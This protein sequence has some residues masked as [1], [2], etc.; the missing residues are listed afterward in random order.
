[1]KR[2]LASK[3]LDLSCLLLLAPGTGCK[4]LVDAPTEL[5]ELSAY[6]FRNFENTDV[7]VLS[8]GLCNLD[9]F[10]S[11]VDLDQN[12]SDLAYSLDP[13]TMDDL[14][15]IVHPD[16]DPATTL[17]V[18]LV[19]ASAFGPRE[20][21]DVILLEDQTPVEPNSPNQYD[22]EFT[23]PG[24]PECF[25]DQDCVL[26]RSMNDI[27]KE[28]F[29]M[30]I[31]YQMHKDF[32]WIEMCEEG[33]TNWAVL[34][35]SWC[36]DEAWG[37]GGDNVILQSYSIDVFMPSNDGGVRY[38]ALWSESDIAGFGD[39][40]VEYSIKLGIHQVFVATEEYLEEN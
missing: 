6:L 8:S 1:M 10:F 32:R 7:E 13:L 9:A 17:P 11:T 36:E 12:Y 22:R 25:R 30:T 23:E 38:M 2:P 14:D 27:V 26:V 4:A 20:Q 24:D 40:T 16:A 33:S 5:N 29:L 18:G 3:A 34:G 15:G 39:D 31:P 35:K 28:N 21:V 19:T 37:E